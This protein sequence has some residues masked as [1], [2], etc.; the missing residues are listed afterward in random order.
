MLK[1][2]IVSGAGH[3]AGLALRTI[4][5]GGSLG[6]LTFATVESAPGWDSSRGRRVDGRGSHAVGRR[7][8]TKGRAAAVRLAIGDWRLAIDD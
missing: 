1:D 6:G 3:R 7:S 2:M 5:R 8:R 4:W